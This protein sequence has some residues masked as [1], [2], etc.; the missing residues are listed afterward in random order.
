MKTEQTEDE[1]WREQCQRQLNRPLALRE[2]YGF[3]S[4]HRPVMD[5]VPFRVFNTM[6]EYREWCHNYLPPHLGYRIIGRENEPQP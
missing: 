5:D 2:R 4:V 3:V 1:L 6:P